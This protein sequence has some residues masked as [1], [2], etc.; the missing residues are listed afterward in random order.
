MLSGTVS[1]QPEEMKSSIIKHLTMVLLLEKFKELPQ[2]LQDLRYEVKFEKVQ[3]LGGLP[4]VLLKAPIESF[5]P[6]DDFIQNV[7]QLS[8]IPAFQ[9]II[10]F[11]APENMPDPLKE[12][13]ISSITT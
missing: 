4:V 2:L 11:D 1:R 3:E 5:L 10:D 7:T 9:E 12:T 6:S 8:G 13:L